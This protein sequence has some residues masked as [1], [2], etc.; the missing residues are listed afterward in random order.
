ME[1]IFYRYLVLTDDEP[2]EGPS[3]KIVSKMYQTLA[4]LLLEG[5]GD[6]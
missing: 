5:E 4:V 1:S 2:D 3:P 6:Q